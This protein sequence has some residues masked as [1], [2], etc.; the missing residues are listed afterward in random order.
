MQ[1]RTKIFSWVFLATIVPLT[2]LALGATYYIEYDYQKNVEETVATNLDT[3]GAALKRRLDLQV[4]LVSGLS[5][6]NAVQ[7][8]VPLLA[9]ADTGRVPAEFNA[10]RSRLNHYFEGF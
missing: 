9:Q 6:S 8:F 3:L 10:S 4:Q 5:K 1:I 2:A 7:E